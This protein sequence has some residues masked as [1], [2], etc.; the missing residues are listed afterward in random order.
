MANIISNAS[1]IDENNSSS[2]NNDTLAG[3]DDD[4]N[5]YAD[6]NTN[7]RSKSK[8]NAMA[9][10]VVIQS[11]LASNLDDRD[12]HD[13]ITNG[14]VP[15]GALVP[16]NPSHDVMDAY[17]YSSLDASATPQ[18]ILSASLSRLEAASK[19]FELQSAVGHTKKHQQMKTFFSLSS[20]A[21]AADAVL[22][23]DAVLH[24]GLSRTTRY[25]DPS[26]PNSRAK[27][28]ATMSTPEGLR[29]MA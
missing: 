26:S 2:N 18:P 27:A 13:I 17:A 20:A 16:S 19:L 4:D 29:N 3:G 24:H 9:R 23:D 8:S 7:T 5:N 21:P 1:I 22:M 15:H 25:L 12:D 14:V 28:F 10:D 11:Y 6:S